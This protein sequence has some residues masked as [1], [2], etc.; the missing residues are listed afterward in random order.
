MMATT[1]VC[2]GWYTATNTGPPRSMHQICT[3]NA[4]PDAMNPAYRMVKSSDPEWNFQ[5]SAS[6]SMKA[7][8]TRNWMTPKK[9]V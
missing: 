9:Q 8:M 2:T 1:S 6:L 5:A 4:T 3:A 7:A